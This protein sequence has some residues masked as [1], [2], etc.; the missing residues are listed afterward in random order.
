MASIDS[1][2][3]KATRLFCETVRACSERIRRTA[4][5]VGES[6]YDSAGRTVAARIGPD[7]WSC[8]TYDGRA[9]S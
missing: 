6:V 9:G 5:R 2:I 3:D 1:P 8:V 7:A 4:A